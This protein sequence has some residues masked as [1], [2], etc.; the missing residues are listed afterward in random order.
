MKKMFLYPTLFLLIM[1][2]VSHAA[3]TTIGTATYK[4]SEYKLIWDDDNNGNSIVWLDYTNRSTD[5]DSQVRWASSL[6]GTG[7]LTINLYN[8]YTVDW[9]GS[10]W[11]LPAAVDGRFE[12]G[13]DGTTTIGYNIT[14]SEMGHLFYEELGNLGE[15]D[16]SGNYQSGYG[17]TET[18]DFESLI[19][20]WYW[21]GTWFTESS[22]CAFVFSMLF[23]F[24]DFNVYTIDDYGLAVRTGHVSVSSTPIP[25]AILLLGSGLLGMV[26]VGR[27]KSLIFG[28]EP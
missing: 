15:C 4:G 28:S 19:A 14:S 10:S 9:G 3:L 5:L 20:S 25:G 8:G 6:N 21:S 23:G 13:Y 1:S 12:Y 2:G 24:Q 17:L 11:R 18:G 22:A 26:V 7:V 27:K 16:T